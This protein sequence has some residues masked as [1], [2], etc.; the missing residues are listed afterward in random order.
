M[1]VNII[2][3]TLHVLIQLEIARDWTQLPQ[4]VFLTAA[5]FSQIISQIFAICASQTST[6]LLGDSV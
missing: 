3:H 4:I 5:R 6:K 2:H 1:S